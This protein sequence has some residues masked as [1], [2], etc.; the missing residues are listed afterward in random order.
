[1]KKLRG[2]QAKIMT[3]DPRKAIMDRSR[4][5]NNYSKWSSRENFLEYKKPKN[6]WNSLNK[7]AKKDYFKK[8]TADGV[9]NNRKF[10][11]TVKPVVISKD[12]FH[13]DNISID[14]YGNIVED[15]QNLTKEFNSYYINMAKTT[16]GKPSMKLENN[17]DYINHSL[18]TKRIIKKY[19]NHLVWKIYKTLSLWKRNLKLNK[20]RLSK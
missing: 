4:F 19:T 17:L 11:N 13:N 15:L 8:A 5:E 3:K 20:W 18:I 1:M 10:W 6:I 9:M 7:K 12:F 2:N 16:S 14:I